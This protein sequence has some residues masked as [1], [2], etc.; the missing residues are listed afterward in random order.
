MEKSEKICSITGCDKPSKKSF[1]STRISDT[2]TRTGLKVKDSRMR[3]TYLCA[4]H[5]KKIKK[6]FKED[7]KPERLRWGH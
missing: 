4:E 6:A 1:S 3:R 2:L 5:Y 7:V